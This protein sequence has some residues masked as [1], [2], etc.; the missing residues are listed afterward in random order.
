VT[1]KELKIICLQKI[2]AITGDTLDIDDTTSP[3]IKSMPGAVNEAMLQ[4]S[5]VG[6]YIRKKIVVAHKTG[7][8]ETVPT[9][10]V[11]GFCKYDLQEVAKDFYSLRGKEVY[12]DD[13][14]SYGKTK[15]FQVEDGSILVLPNER[16]GS[17]TIY[18]NSYPKEMTSETVDSE[19]LYIDPEVAALIPLY[20]A[21][22]IYKDDDIGQSV[23]FLNE[24]EA[25]REILLQRS[26]EAEQ[27]SYGKESFSS[28]T[29]W[30]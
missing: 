25:K 21:S 7:E 16:S 14:E 18:Y 2:F 4:L 15:D 22:Q 10:M 26:M 13:G 17:Y 24:F 11:T 5:T 8:G 12:I 19:E 29:G 3:Y 27:E 6:K 28:V 9:E 23:Q 30:W 20:V 1:W